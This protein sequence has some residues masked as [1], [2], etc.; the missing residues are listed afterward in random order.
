MFYSTL[1]TTTTVFSRRHDHYHAWKESICSQL[2][3]NY[4]GTQS[5]AL[6]VPIPMLTSHGI[7]SLLVSC[8]DDKLWG[9]CNSAIGT[10][11]SIMA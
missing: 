6:R 4:K 1:A 5:L 9:E 7:L 3:G 11:V 10:R 2:E 8:R